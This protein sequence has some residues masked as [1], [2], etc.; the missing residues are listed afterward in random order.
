M[1]EGGV[2]KALPR[3]GKLSRMRGQVS[4]GKKR[5]LRSK[6]VKMPHFAGAL[7]IERLLEQAF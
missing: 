5:A 6:T 7:L 2:H 1:G 4:N 3:G